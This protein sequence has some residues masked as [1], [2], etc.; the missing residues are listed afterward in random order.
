MATTEIEDAQTIKELAA[1]VSLQAQVSN[2]VWLGLLT[3]AVI[4]LLPRVPKAGPP[5]ELDLPFGLGQVDASWFYVILFLMLVVLTIAFSAA[6]AQQVRAQKLA[7]SFVD[8]MAGRSPEVA[9]MH[10]RELFDMLRLPSVNRVAP[11]AQSIRG[12]YQFYHN[13]MN[14]PAWLRKASTIY[15]VLLKLVS[16]AVYFG[17][18]AFALWQAYTKTQAVG[19]RWLVAP[20]IILAT[21]IVAAATLL[22]VV[23]EDLR[24]SMEILPL[25]FG[26][27]GRS[28]AK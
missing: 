28:P 22:Q 13:A 4:T 9:G 3:V 21:A 8:S 25:I 19:L 24:Y 27:S 23:V 17:L 5:N 26:S 11:L 15:Y 16:M 1:A 14:C 10:P 20:W 18:P 2:R 12:P 7:Q 6:H